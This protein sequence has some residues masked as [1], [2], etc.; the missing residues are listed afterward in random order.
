MTAAMRLCILAVTIG[1]MLAIVLLGS[2]SAPPDDRKTSLEATSTTAVVVA[3]PSID[4]TAQS[5]RL[6]SSAHPDVV[7]GMPLPALMNPPRPTP[8]PERRHGEVVRS[9]SDASRSAALLDRWTVGQGETLSEIAQKALGSSNRWREIVAINSGIDPDRLKVG[10]VLKLPPRGTGGETR[11]SSATQPSKA[12]THVVQAGETL[13]SIAKRY[14]GSV[15]AWRGVFDANS[16]ALH[17]DPNRLVVGMTLVIP[18][19]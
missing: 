13:S 7:M 1:S 3:G 16:K 17:G 11:R 12:T 4:T 14:L 15:N 8:L 6:S 10:A 2:L 9:G 5:N 19:R 18:A